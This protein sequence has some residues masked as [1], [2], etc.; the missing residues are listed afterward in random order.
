MAVTQ[1]L[2]YHDVQL[3]DSDVALFA[4]RQWLN[5]NA[6]NFYLQ[7]LTHDALNGGAV[8]DLLLMDPAVVSC[9]MLQCDDDDEYEDLGRGLTLDSKR[10]C[11]IPMNDNDQFGGESTHWS[12]LVYRRDERTFA[13]YDSSSGHNAHAAKRIMAEFEK[14]LR[15]CGAVDGHAAKATFVDVR[16]TPQQ[17][18]GYDCGMYVLV[19]TEYLCRKYVHEQQQQRGDGGNAEP[20]PSMQAFVTPER[21]TRTRL[22]M[23]ALVQRLR[24]EQQAAGGHR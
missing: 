17:R 3:Y 14:M 16:E 9:M 7:F 8:A 22:E 13:H 20:M 5:D 24:R 21:V 1:V 10:V 11:F 19:I 12:L 15:L 4:T 18:N 23:P 6:I 2:N